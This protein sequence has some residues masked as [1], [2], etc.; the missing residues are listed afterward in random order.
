MTAY[1]RL[2]IADVSGTLPEG[3]QPDQAPWRSFTFTTRSGR[4]HR[5]DFVRF[6]A[7]HDAVLSDGDAFFYV[8]R[9]SFSWDIRSDFIWDVDTG[10][11]NGH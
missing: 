11:Q 2:L 7:L 9:P 8:F 1:N 6:D 10:D 3:W 5:L 4:V